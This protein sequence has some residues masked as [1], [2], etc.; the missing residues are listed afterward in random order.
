MIAEAG[1]E[2]DV[3]YVDTP[4]QQW[5]G[6]VMNQEPVRNSLGQQ[7]DVVT[8]TVGVEPEPPPT[9]RPPQTN[10]PVTQAPP[11][12]TQAPPPATAAPT[13]PPTT[14]PPTA[15]PTTAAPTLQPTTAPAGP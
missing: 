1:F 14:P 11:R 9:T 10:P 5:I 7:G 3:V 6:N 15:P 4:D 2:V 13:L 12:P 8:I